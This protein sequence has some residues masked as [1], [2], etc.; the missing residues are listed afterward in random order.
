MVVKPKI[1]L[2]HSALHT[3]THFLMDLLASL[4]PNGIPHGHG[5]TRNVTGNGATMEHSTFDDG[6]E[7]F[8]LDMV[9]QAQE[10]GYW[11]DT[12]QLLALSFHN[13]RSW[14][15]V[16]DIL[17]NG[18]PDLPVCVPMRDP[19]LAI[20]T[21]IWRELRTVDG[22]LA[23][24]EDRRRLRVLDQMGSIGRL[25]AIPKKNVFVLPI[26][27]EDKYSRC[28]KMAKFCGFDTLADSFSKKIESWSP[29]NFTYKGDFVQRRESNGAV[30]DDEGYRKIKLA[31]SDNNIQYIRKHLDLELDMLNEITI[32]NP[33]IKTRMQELGYNKLSW[34]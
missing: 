7:N 23:N 6:L 24:D 10:K 22:L 17:L 9:R 25:L 34:W 12:W 19:L 4:S 32:K 30:F 13:R 26:D 33:R 27:L 2:I 5:W 28:L 18:K 31:I 20:N 14:S 15:A 29:L 8:V 11:D 16:Y 3:G 1:I 21:R